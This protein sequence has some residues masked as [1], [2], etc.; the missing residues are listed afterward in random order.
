MQALATSFSGWF[1]VCFFCPVEACLGKCLVS[2][3]AFRFKFSDSSQD[4]SVGTMP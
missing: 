4:V 3:S 1:T 2:S